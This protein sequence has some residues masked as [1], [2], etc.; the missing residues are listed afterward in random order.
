MGH[1]IGHVWTMAQPAANF[2]NEGWAT[3]A[4]SLILDKE[5]GPATVKAF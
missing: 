3:Y 1:E 5:F 4:E 2:L